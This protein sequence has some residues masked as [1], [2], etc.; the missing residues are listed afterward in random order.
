MR[1]AL[2]ESG[3]LVKIEDYTTNIGRSERTGVVVEPKLSLQWFVRMTDLRDPAVRAVEEREVRFYPDN[4][5]NSYQSWM[6][7]LR[8][9]C[10]SRQLWWGHRIP[11]WYLKSE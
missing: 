6:N 1:P 3:H 7:G 5:R 4:I 10:I 2:E 9:W 11:A 8:D